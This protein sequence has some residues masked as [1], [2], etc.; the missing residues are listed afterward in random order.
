VSD[1]SKSVAK[2]G[3][4]GPRPGAGAPRGNLNALKH[5]RRSTQFS[6]LGLLLAANPKIRDAL[7]ALA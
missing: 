2:T 5:G 3:K 6:Q 4:G 7:L 1:Q